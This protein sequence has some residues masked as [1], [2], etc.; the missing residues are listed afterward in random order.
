VDYT[1]LLYIILTHCGFY[2]LAYR[3]ATRL[4]VITPW[5]LTGT[6]TSYIP[7]TTTHRVYKMPLRKIIRKSPSIHTRIYSRSPSR[8]R[9]RSRSRSPRRWRRGNESD[10]EEFIE[11]PAAGEISYE[12]GPP[13]NHHAF[14]FS[15]GDIV[16]QVGTLISGY[17]SLIINTCYCRLGWPSSKSILFS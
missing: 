11:V 14:Y 7:T 2:F 4:I 5:R 6:P 3:P 12:D 17:R 8:R 13:R 10:T 1:S 16:I 15:S 9:T